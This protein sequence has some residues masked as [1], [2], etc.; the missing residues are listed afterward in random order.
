LV[1]GVPVSL[2]RGVSTRIPVSIAPRDLTPP[3]V[4]SIT[5]APGPGAPATDP[6]VIT[7]SEPILVRGF[8]DGVSLGGPVASAYRQVWSADAR[9][10]T[11]T[12]DRPQP[13]GYYT[14]F[15]DG[16]T[17]LQGNRFDDKS[18]PLKFTIGRPPPRILAYLDPIW[19]QPGGA[20]TLWVSAEGENLSYQWHRNG[21]PIT[22][23]TGPVLR[24][25]RLS[26]LDLASSFLV[27]ITNPA[28]TASLAVRLVADNSPGR[29]VNLSVRTGTGPGDR[30]LI[31]GFACA[32]SETAPDA[33]APFLLR[34]I[35]PTLAS[36]GVPGVLGDPRIALYR[37][38]SPLAANDDWGSPAGSAPALA[39]ATAGVGAFALPA[40]SRDAAMQA[41][42][43]PAGYTLHVTSPAASGI[44]LAEIY[45]VAS[46][47]PTK[48]RLTNLSARALAGSGADTLIA[49]FVIGGGN[50]RTYL[51]RAIGPTL[52]SFGV[53]GVLADPR[54]EIRNEFGLVADNHDW[55]TGSAFQALPALSEIVGAFPLS[56]GS[57]DAALVATLGPGSYTVQVKGADNTPGIAL[58]E[59]YEIP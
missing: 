39:T 19:C 9:V 40:A 57:K 7:F 11:I 13:D 3:T 22:G 12:F 21:V 47:D 58:I 36:F 29:L 27:V 46:A 52:A 44:A 54:L 48:P 24:L 25:N 59:L 4:V 49:G 18:P 16:L 50:S 56:P 30:T 42:L 45:H 51:V 10:V 32:A 55:S 23:A 34:G 6:V 38:A 1:A 43:G 53:N 41:S 28:G 14:V 5:R 15:L 20:A 2:G 8:Q 33:A 31:V 37:D 26:A 35:G 17:D